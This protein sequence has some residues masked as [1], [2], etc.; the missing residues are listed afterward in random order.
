[1]LQ[2]PA[3]VILAASVLALF[4]SPSSAATEVELRAYPRPMPTDVSYE[5]VVGSQSL[6]AMKYPVPIVGWK[7]HPEEVHVTPTGG[8][9]LPRSRPDA[10]LYLAV[11]L[12]TAGTTR[13]AD[14]S[15]LMPDP[16]QA[17]SR[18]VD[19][20]LPA[21]EYTWRAG[22]LALKQLAFATVAVG[23]EVRTGR[24]PL[25]T[26]V[27]YTLTNH[28]DQPRPLSFALQFGEAVGG[29]SLRKLPPVYPRELSWRPPYVLEPDGKVAAVLLTPGA[30][31]SLQP[32][33]P[34]PADQ[35]DKYLVLNA[36]EAAVESPDYR[37]D[38]VREGDAVQ[39]GEWRSPEGVEFYVEASRVHN[40]PIAVDVEVLADDK[41]A[42]AVGRIFRTGFST[43]QRPAA[44]YLAPGEHGGPV[45]W[46]ELSKHLPQ[47]R[48]R[49]SL[50]AYYPVG[51]AREAVGAWEPII[52]CAQPGVVPRFKYRT[53][54]QPDENRLRVEVRLAPGESKNIELVLPYFPLARVALPA[55]AE[56][57]VDRQLQ[58]LRRFW[59]QELNRNAEFVV[60]EQRVRDAY[61][62]CLANNLI[63]TDRDPQTGRLHMHPD[64]TAYEYVWAGDSG[65]IL[66]AMDQ[67]GYHA[68][69]TDWMEV[70]LTTQGARGPDGE[71]ESHE[72]FFSGDA[73]PKWM[74]DN[75]FILW[76]MS[77]HYKLTDDAAWLRRTARNM[78]K[79]CEWIIRERARTKKLEADGTRPRHYG[80]L[81]KGTPSDIGIWDY[82]Y[83]SDNY[84][85]LG[86]RGAADVL[87]EIGMK[88]EADRL[89]A[90]ADD[91]RRCIR[92]SIE[93]SINHDVEPPFVPPGP[94]WNAQPT[95]DYMQKTWYS[96]TGPIYLTEG[97]LI[98]P[99]GEQAGWILEWMER[100][101]LYTGL[102]AFGSGA[103]DPYYVFNQAHTQLRRG[104]TDKFL[105]TLYSLM[106]YGMSR[107]TYATIEGHN[108][109]TGFNGEAWDAN[110]QPHM[111]S[112]SRFLA[113][114]RIALVLE[115]GPTLHLL[116]GTPRGWLAPGN[117]IE[118]RRAPTWFGE[119]SLT[120]HADA[121]GRAVEKDL[122]P[123]DAA[124]QPST[125]GLAAAKEQTSSG[126]RE[127][128][129]TIDPPR[130]QPAEIVLHVRPP[131]AWGPIR[132]V[133]VEGQAWEDFAAGSVRLGRLKDKT[134]LVCRFE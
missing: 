32:L 47:G 1:M 82:W 51:A 65:V 6:P 49:C 62:V 109:L 56:L 11:L 54:G 95:S 97:G 87:A 69:A 26:Y 118:V 9:V 115:D 114:L 105:W 3:L 92:D 80:L 34:L 33:P 89:A 133:E 129:L 72:G 84:S 68:E 2:Q 85:Y 17:T 91:Y 102:P 74:N 44:E 98:D 41:P 132:E 128:R 125:R 76:A 100:L 40:L 24:E 96:I 45:P 30:L 134:R 79:S 86:L 29:H 20:Y 15:R 18:L 28:G 73:P 111:H 116:A 93:S 107:G 31:V 42:A 126:P 4:G 21:I 39:I 78:L 22:D 104:E 48:S 38:L 99:R 70:F 25:L 66:Q 88:S 50:K 112:N 16:D 46:A 103:I 8:L 130:R 61:R 13:P 119:V 121:G 94:Y 131:T 77:E 10:G 113:Q 108:L 55:R 75:G 106:A 67:Y 90:E 27:R 12:E 5:T 120:A 23:E 60:P 83:W 123:A 43:D 127:I 101:C 36:D 7:H 58:R 19:G 124:T 81:P 110:R 71:V 57:D 37:I 35:P 52:Y 59:S 117:T 64:P 14:E 53:G 122:E 63:L